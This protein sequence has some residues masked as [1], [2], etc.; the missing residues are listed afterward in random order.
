[1]TTHLT[2]TLW[3]FAATLALASA[4]HAISTFG[5]LSNFD[6]VNDTGQTCNG[7]RIELDGISSSNVTYTFGS[8]Y[9]R[10]GTPTITNFAGGCYVEYAATF[11]AGAWSTYT[12]AAT[13]AI[14]TGG[15]QFWTGGDPN[16]PLKNGGVPGDHFGLGLT[17]N[18]TNTVYQWLTGDA[19]GNLHLAG[20]SIKLPAPAIT[21]AAAGNPGAPAAVQVVVQAPAALVSLFG[22]PIWVKVFIADA[23]EAPV[24]LDDL[25]VGNAVVSDQ[26]E[27]EWLLLQKGY[28]DHESL[29]SGLKDLNPGAES[30][31]Q[32]YEF[33]KYNPAAGFDADG[34][35]LV[36]SP[37]DLN[38][39][40][41]VGNFIG[42]QIVALNLAELPVPEPTSLTL[43]TLGA[44]TLLLRRRS[45]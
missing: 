22:T 39:P 16:Y 32:R 9:N 25:L 8:P 41:E 33:Y 38:N 23:P 15:H 13:A 17:A 1:M 28:A 44:A 42:S 24:P 3:A 14:T 2:R 36:D 18:P 31:V 6:A 4:A 30:F 29:D 5:T 43:L 12:P 11:S 35:A 37:A 21:A 45:T 34:Q 7:F 27:I 20:P 40:W 19:G 26:V 10:Y